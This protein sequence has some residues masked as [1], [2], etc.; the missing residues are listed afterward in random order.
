M[1]RRNC[2]RCSFSSWEP[3]NHTPLLIRPTFENW[4]KFTNTCRYWRIPLWALAFFGGY[5]A[6]EFI[7]VATDHGSKDNKDEKNNPV[8]VPFTEQFRISSSLLEL[9]PKAILLTNKHDDQ[10]WQNNCASLKI[11][12]HARC[13][14]TVPLT[15]LHWIRGLSEIPSTNTRTRVWSSKR[16]D[17]PQLSKES[18]NNESQSDS[19]SL[20]LRGQRSAGAA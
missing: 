6:E 7:N 20:E 19:E 17:F 1:K 16:H 5:L 10:L 2:F 18:R 9:V 11:S 3:E 12:K 13:F 8:E 14:P 4:N 15:V